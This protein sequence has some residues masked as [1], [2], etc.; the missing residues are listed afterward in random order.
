MILIK[1]PMQTPSILRARGVTA[2][3]NLC[4]QHD[5]DPEAFKK[6]SV[7]FDNYI[8]GAESVKNTLRKAQYDKCAF[9]E[10]LIT[11]IAYGDVEHFRPKAAHRQGPKGFLTRPGYYWLAYEWSNVLFCCQLC[12]QRFK[13]NHFSL[14]NPSRRARPH[15]N[16][17]EDEQPMFINPAGENPT[18]FP[19]FR[20]EYLSPTD[21]NPRGH[22]TIESLGLNREK[23][24]EKRRDTLRPIKDL[25]V[26]RRLFAVLASR[27]PSPENVKGLGEIDERLAWYIKKY[28]SDSAEYAAMV[29]A[30]LRARD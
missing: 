7:Q 2:T 26:C 3:R 11:P 13:R 21:G 4:E 17:I 15:H 14:A 28:D 16:D 8:Y 30:A 18:E 10:T 29:R 9:C 25:L 5:A 20:E 22:A 19:E 6:G 1:K 23:L 12:N 24:V 27:D